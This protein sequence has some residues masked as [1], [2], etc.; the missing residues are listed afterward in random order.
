MSSALRELDAR[1]EVLQTFVQE[2]QRR[3]G[4]PLPRALLRKLA[5]IANRVPLELPAALSAA[6]AADRLEVELLALL[7]AMA[8]TSSDMAQAVERVEV[9]RASSTRGT[10]AALFDL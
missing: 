1:L 6:H 3:E 10:R 8:K 9:Q 5:A 2:V 4:A 7:G